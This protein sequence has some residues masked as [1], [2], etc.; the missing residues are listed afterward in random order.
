[1]LRLELT[2]SCSSFFPV[3]LKKRFALGIPGKTQDVQVNDANENSFQASNF[4][5][6]LYP[7]PPAS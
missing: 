2:V 4:I 7:R 6:T 1:M 5:L 3:A